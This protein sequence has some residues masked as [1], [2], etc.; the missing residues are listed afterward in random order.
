MKVNG[1]RQDH[2]SPV[3]KFG[4][5]SES[6]CSHFFLQTPAIPLL[7]CKW[8]PQ[9]AAL[10]RF[11]KPSLTRMV[12]GHFALEDEISDGYRPHRLAG[13]LKRCKQPFNWAR[14]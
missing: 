2:W 7:K 4:D 12:R 10:V 14:R 6:K 5:H 11:Q 3:L 9:C 8:H 1:R 13:Y